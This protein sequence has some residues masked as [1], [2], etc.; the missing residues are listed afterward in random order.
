ML[1]LDNI[2]FQADEKTEILKNVTL[3]IDDRFTAITGPN[4]GGSW[5]LRYPLSYCT[6]APIEF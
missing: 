5:P 1:L 2:S 6:L 4:G 3:E